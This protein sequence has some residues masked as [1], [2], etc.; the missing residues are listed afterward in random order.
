VSVIATPL[1]PVGAVT[2]SVK[3]TAGNTTTGIDIDVL[4]PLA[5]VAIAV[6]VNV[7]D[8]L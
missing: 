1:L 4:C 5:S 6:T 7:P 2:V 8:S 3:G